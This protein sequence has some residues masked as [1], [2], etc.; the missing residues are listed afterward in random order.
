MKKFTQLRT[1]KYYY[2][3]ISKT[4]TTTIDNHTRHNHSYRIRHRLEGRDMKN[5][6]SSSTSTDLQGF[7]NLVNLAK[8]HEEIYTMTIT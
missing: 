8:L 6:D 5:P 1:P 7:K 2:N 4:Q 3:K